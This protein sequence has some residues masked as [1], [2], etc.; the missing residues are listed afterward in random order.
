MLAAAR[1]FKIRGAYFRD[2]LPAICGKMQLRTFRVKRPEKNQTS[3]RVCRSFTR[4]KRHD[5]EELRVFP[6]TD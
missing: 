4:M 2:A 1:H 5:P 3:Y 6:Q